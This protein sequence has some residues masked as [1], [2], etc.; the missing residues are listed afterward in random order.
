MRLSRSLLRPVTSFDQQF[1]YFNVFIAEL[2]LTIDL[3]TSELTRNDCR[4]RSKE[5]A[6]DSIH[7]G[8]YRIV[9]EM[10]SSSSS[11]DCVSVPITV[12]TRRCTAIG[13][14]IGSGSRADPHLVPHPDPPPV[15]GPFL[16]VGYGAYGM[17]LSVGYDPQVMTLLQRGFSVGYAHCRGGGEYG[18]HWHTA[19]KGMLKWNTFNDFAACAEHLISRGYTSPSL[20]CG[21]GTSAGGLV[22]GVM[23]NEFPHLFAA[24]VMR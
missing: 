10:A 23:A 4:V 7:G 20:L 19:G 13:T 16:L 1:A 5:S 9:T 15:P 12:V 14:A 3:M 8:E 18:S 21:M 11:G 6:A 2:H 24:L 22:M 17:S